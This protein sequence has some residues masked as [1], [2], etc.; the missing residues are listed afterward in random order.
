MTD[1]QS[2]RW[3]LVSEFLAVATKEDH[4]S[5]GIIHLFADNMAADRNM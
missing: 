1:C 5:V 3:L 4:Q 2:N